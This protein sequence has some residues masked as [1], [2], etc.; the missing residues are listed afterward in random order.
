MSTLHIMAFL[1]FVNVVSVMD[2]KPSVF[3]QLEILGFSLV[4]EYKF[5]V[6]TLEV[7]DPHICHTINTLL[8]VPGGGV[9]GELE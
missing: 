5:L 3:L 6:Q 9:G 8:L 7:F 2:N 1:P 4:V